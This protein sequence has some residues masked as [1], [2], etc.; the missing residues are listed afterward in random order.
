MEAVN[1]ILAQLFAWLNV[2][3]NAVGGVCSVMVANMPGW[4]SNTIISAVVGVVL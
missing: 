3:T 1:S 4:L 2:A